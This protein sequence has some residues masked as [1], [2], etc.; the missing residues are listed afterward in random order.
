MI[1]R[2]ILDKLSPITQEEQR[3][4]QGTHSIDKSLYMDGDRNI[5]EGRKLLEAGTKEQV[6]YTPQKAETKQFLEFY[7]V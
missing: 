5:I 1:S 3:I 6:L 7:G 4:L 2:E